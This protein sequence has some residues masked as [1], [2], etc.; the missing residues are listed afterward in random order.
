LHILPDYKRHSQ[1][2]F[3]EDEGVTVLEKVHFGFT[4]FACGLLWTPALWST[5][6]PLDN[7]HSASLHKHQ[8]AG[9]VR[10]TCYRIPAIFVHVSVHS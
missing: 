5:A 2:L 1:L 10:R 3:N 7:S 8:V 6:Q 9:L 4:I